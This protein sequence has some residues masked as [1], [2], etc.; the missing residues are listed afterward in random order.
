MPTV[1][2]LIP[3]FKPEFLSKALLSAQ[4]QTF[5]DIEILVGD[6]THDARL[7]SL[8]EGLDDP[9]IRYFHHGF[10]HGARNAQALWAK[11]SGVYV[12]W[13]FDDDFLLP[14]SVETLVRAMAE[15]PDSIMAFHQCI[16]I[17][18]TDKVTHTPQPLLQAGTLALVSRQD[19]VTQM[20]ARLDNFIG[21]PSNTMLV[22][23]KIN[24]KTFRK[25][26]AYH[27][28]FLTDVAMYLNSAAEA[29]LIAVGAYLSAFRQH[30]AQAS[31]TAS[32]IRSAGCYEWEVF[33]RGEAAAGNIQAHELA[34]AKQQL[35]RLY[36]S[37]GRRLPDLLPFVESVEELST[38]AP[39]E[40]PFSPQFEA[41]IMAS[42]S[43]IAARIAERKRADAAPAATP[44]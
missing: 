26:G 44:G 18:A 9:R 14:N 15:Y 24:Q 37:E 28:Q 42:Q 2:I 27:T 5:T 25:Y 4:E 29:P 8:V 34:T 33:I 31:G 38:L 22:R 3:A 43:A 30:A 6:D 39:D 21:A 36:A 16:F 41:N 1:S 10:G 20:V 40:L 7:Q 23:E 17:D 13:L 32:P 12:K 19:L 11:A 35:K